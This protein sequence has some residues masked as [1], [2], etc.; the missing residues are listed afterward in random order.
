MKKFLSLTAAL[1]PVVVL[2]GCN[3][4]TGANGV[5]ALSHGIG[6][7]TGYSAYYNCA[8]ART[9]AAATEYHGLE[10][11]IVNTS[12]VPVRVSGGLIDVVI[13]PGEWARDCVVTQGRSQAVQ[14][15]AVGTKPNRDGRYASDSWTAQTGWE[16]G[17]INRTVWHI[18]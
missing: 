1:A 12:S 4:A 13:P 10:T 2:G 11:R 14:Y 18:R 16:Y 6:L 7:S 5:G 9:G 3:L 17:S 8:R 15:V